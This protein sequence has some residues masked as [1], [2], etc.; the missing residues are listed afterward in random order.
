MSV[1]I[2]SGFVGIDEDLTYPRIGWNNISGTVTSTGTDADGFP[3]AN[4]RTNVTY[5]A[6]QS[7]TA[8]QEWRNTFASAQSVAYV[9]VAVHNAGTLG[10]TITVRKL[11]GGTWSDWT[12]SPSASPS[13]DDAILFLLSPE[14]V[15][16]I[17]IEVTGAAARIG[18]IRAGAIMEWPRRA[19]WTGLPITE[20][21]Q[22]RY[23]FNESE[24]GNWLGRTVVS[25]GN[26]FE[27]NIDNLSET[28]RTSAFADFAAHANTGD[29]PFFI[30]P[31]PLDY[32]NEVAYAWPTETVRMSR[33]I[34]NKLASGSVGLSLMG[35]RAP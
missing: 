26:Q 30:A 15:D 19:Q 3:A 4:A 35:Y 25:S 13:N 20:S 24:T 1:V 16:G 11:S 8:G 12:G 6:W 2:Q 34:P 28:Y 31:R 9:G 7:T 22:L 17:G 32:P 14:S 18:V 5:T 27:V 21:Q 33:E 23:N 10:A 29:G